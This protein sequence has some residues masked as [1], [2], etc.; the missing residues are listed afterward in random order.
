MGKNVKFSEEDYTKVSKRY[1]DIE[2]SFLVSKWFLVGKLEFW[3]TVILLM[4]IQKYRN[5]HIKKEKE[6]SKRNI[7]T[8]IFSKHL[9]N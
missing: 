7:Q 6:I 5:L 8:F 1:D 2:A 3:I 4:K 9:L